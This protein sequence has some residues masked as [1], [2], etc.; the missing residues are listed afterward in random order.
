MNNKGFTLIELMAVIMLLA[1]ITTIATTSVVGIINSSKEKSL[2]VLEKNINV[3][4]QEY[5][6]ECENLDIF[7]SDFHE[8]ACNNLIV[9]SSGADSFAKYANIS[10]GKLLQYGYLK[11]TAVLI[12]EAGHEIKIIE[13]PVSNKSMNDCVIKIMKYFN[14]T[15]GSVWYEIISVPQSGESD[16]KEYCNLEF[17]NIE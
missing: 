5:F 1:L 13:N 14:E 11:S 17:E 6:E 16:I 2:K 8:E 9:D 4:A 12:D 3:A 7:A 15:N 10:L